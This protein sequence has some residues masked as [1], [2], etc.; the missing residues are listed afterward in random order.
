M[1]YIHKHTMGYYLAF[2]NK[3]IMFYVTVWMNLEDIMLSAMNSHRTESRM[4]VARAS[5][6]GKQGVVFQ[7]V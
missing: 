2:K 6:E 7:L 5:R 3:R 1:V 4:V